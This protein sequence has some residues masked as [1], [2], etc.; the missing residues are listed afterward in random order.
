[1]PGPC[2]AC[3]REPP[4]F[5][6]VACAYDYGFPVDR[7][8]H[9]F[10][11]SADLVAGAW[12]AGAIARAV[13]QAPVPDLVV[14]V[15]ASRQRIRERGLDAA[16]FLA[17][18]VAAERDLAFDPR[19]AARVRHTPTQHGLDRE[20]RLRNLA[21]AFATVRPVA[22]RHVLVVDD[23]MTTGATLGAVAGALKAAGAA[24]VTAAVA[25]RTPSRAGAG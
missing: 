17:S 5:D 20:E 18:L 12:L 3:L 25:A 7:L 10:K 8:V 15:P 23:V 16:R 19:V 11:Y 9:R 6:G 14:A 4:P 21:G 24:R 22:G 1:M 13:D 2:G